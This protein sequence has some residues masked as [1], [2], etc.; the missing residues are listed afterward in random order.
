MTMSDLEASMLLHIRVNGLP[1]PLREYRFHPKRRWRFD[2]A[3]PDDRVA[4]EVEGGVY[5]GGRH[6][7][8]R[9]FQ[10]DCVKYN[11]AALLGWTVLRVTGEQIDD[12][13]ALDWLRRALTVQGAERPP[14]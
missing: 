8:G 2:M 4:L 12:G 3:W 13:S 7:R 14:F 5:T 11:E 1:E 10:E 9:G 6:T